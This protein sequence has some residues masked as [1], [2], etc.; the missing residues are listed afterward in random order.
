MRSTAAVL[1]GALA[2]TGAAAARAESY[3]TGTGFYYKERSTRVVAPSVN[4]HVELPSGWTV[5]GGVL[6]DQIT[7]AS[8]AFT[9]TD[10]PFTEYRIQ[11]TLAA[12]K[13]FGRVFKGG[14]N[15]RVSNESDYRSLL[16]GVRGSVLLN[17]ELTALGVSVQHQADALRQPGP[18]GIRRALNTTYLSLNGSQVVHP[19][20]L[21]GGTLNVQV[22]RGYTENVYRVEQHPTAREDYSLGYFARFRYSPWGTGIIF[23]QCGHY[24]SWKHKGLTTN[25]EV[26]QTLTPWLEVV[27]RV[28]VHVQDAVFFV[29]RAEIP[30]PDDP[31]GDPIQLFTTDPSLT[32]MQTV[33][34]GAQLVFSPPA[35]DGMQINP[36]YYFMYQ[37]TRYGNAHLAQVVLYYPFSIE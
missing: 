10:E 14:L 29:N 25:L 3:I 6:V 24:S 35:L 13:L 15:A 1:A 27:P 12:D 30:D 4:A 23:E 21:L 11:G 36:S 34:V 17:D 7:S 26:W 16:G 37:S 28:R 19:R 31:A 32:A 2:L 5:D 33:T 20:L 9:A 18:S 22:L 8:G